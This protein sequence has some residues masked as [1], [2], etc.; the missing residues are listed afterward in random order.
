MQQEIGEIRD[1]NRIRI[2]VMCAAGDVSRRSKVMSRRDKEQKIDQGK[3]A[4]DGR[5]SRRAWARAGY[6]NRNRN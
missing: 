5:R 1:Y 6:G 4:G 2:Q 3:A